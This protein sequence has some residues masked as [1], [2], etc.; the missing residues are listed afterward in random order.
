MIPEKLAVKFIKNIVRNILESI[1]IF[2]LKEQ[3]NP[4]RNCNK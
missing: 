3:I 1:P 4:H 2:K